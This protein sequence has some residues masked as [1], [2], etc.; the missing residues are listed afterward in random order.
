MF[1]LYMHTNHDDLDHLL[2][3]WK[4]TPLPEG[5]LN[6]PVWRRIEAVQSGSGWFSRLVL[7]FYELDDRFARPRVLMALLAFS[8]LLGV[9]VAELRTRYEAYQVDS[10]MSARYLSMLDVQ[11]R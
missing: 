10:E 4:D 9:G 3:E 2:K 7:S 8:L 1:L 6:V 11:N 5:R